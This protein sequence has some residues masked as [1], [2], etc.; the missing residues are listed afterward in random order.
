MA[1]SSIQPKIKALYNELSKKETQIADFMLKDPKK[2]SRMTINEIGEEL[3]V[4]PSTVFQFTRKLGYKGFRD[5]RNDLLA[6]EFDPAISVHENIQPG[7]DELS[8]AT[9]VFSSSIVSLRD[10]AKLLTQDSLKKASE[11]LL[12]AKT[13]TFF[14]VGGSNVVAYDAYHK[15]LRSPLHVQYA[16]DVHVQRMLAARLDENDCAVITTHTGLTHET[17]DIARV[18]REAG[19]SIIATTSYPSAQLANLADVVLVSTA[20]ETEF[21][22]E[23]LSSRIAQLGIIDSLF[24]I[25]MFNS[26]ERSVEPLRRIRKVISPTREGIN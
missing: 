8:I 3:S 21:R 6:E 25:V 26:G 2:F 20:E 13:V 24:T 15:F 1:S 5:F 16:M 4:A 7:E 18:A 11:L 9:K 19:A 22:P 23:S 10:T 12:D 17:L 14:G